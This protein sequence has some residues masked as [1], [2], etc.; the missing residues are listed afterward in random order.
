MDSGNM[1]L[2][3]A[4][5]RNDA[6]R[7]HNSQVR[8]KYKSDANTLQDE[9]EAETWWHGISDA[10]GGE[11]SVAAIGNEYLRAKNSPL[12]YGSL[13][14]QDLSQ[15]AE[16]A[17]NITRQAATSIGE[18]INKAKNLTTNI[19]TG[20]TTKYEANPSTPAS[21]DDGVGAGTG[22]TQIETSEQ[23]RTSGDTSTATD[24]AEST[25]DEASDA[26]KGGLTERL[27][28]KATGKEVGSIANIGIGKA[29]GNI[30]GAVDIVKDFENV[31]KPGG[32]FGGTGDNSVD[33]TANKLTVAGTILDVSSIAL[34]FLAPIATAVSLAGGIEGTIGAIKD[35]QTETDKQAGDYKK[36]VQSTVAPPSLAGTGFL[37][38]TPIDPESHVH[39]NVVSSF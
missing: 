6:I 23:A 18:G 5:D 8:Q 32:F 22:G 38:A 31:G 35:N 27:I 20:L 10:L 26:S 19:V 21:T 2:E 14:K 24:L 9:H 37:T 33:E 30:G 11:H 34:P 39:Q 12:S 3:G 25:A 17:G 15:A 16:G 4:V 1:L 29:L 7:E 28:A 13:V 36:N